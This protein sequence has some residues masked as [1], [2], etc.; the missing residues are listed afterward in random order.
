MD[1]KEVKEKFQEIIAA[2]EKE[3]VP[4]F[5]KMFG[6][7]LVTGMALGKTFNYAMKYAYLEGAQDLLRSASDSIPEEENSDNT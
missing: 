2:I 3:R 5:F 1:K 4:I 6:A 7:I